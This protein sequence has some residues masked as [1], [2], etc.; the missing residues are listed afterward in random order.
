[1]AAVGAPLTAAGDRRLTRVGRIL[2]ATKL[3]K[4][5]QLWNGLRGEMALVGLWPESMPFAH[6]L[7]SQFVHVLDHRLGLL[8]PS[9]VIFR[10]EC[11]LFAEYDDPA[12]FLSSRERRHDRQLRIT[13]WPPRVVRGSASHTAIA[14]SVNH[15]G[16]LPRCRSA[17]S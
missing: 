10:S 5:P 4:L 9:Q 6:Y 12:P 1:M 7:Q 11:A 8:G 14:A 17:E 13:P 2:C 16:K 3:D 15:S